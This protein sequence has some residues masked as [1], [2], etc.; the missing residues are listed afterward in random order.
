MAGEPG[1]LTNAQAA[2]LAGATEADIYEI[3]RQEMAG[4]LPVA[5]SG[6]PS[7]GAYTRGGEPF[8]PQVAPPRR[9]VRVEAISAEEMK[10]KKGK[11]S[12]RSTVT[13]PIQQ[14]MNDVTTTL[15]GIPKSGRTLTREALAEI[16]MGN[17]R[18]LQ[19]PTTGQ[20]LKDPA[21]GEPMTIGGMQILKAKGGVPLGQFQIG[22]P[23][24]YKPLTGAVD[25][26]ITINQAQADFMK[27]SPEVIAAMQDQ[28]SAGGWMGFDSKGEPDVAF[29]R[30]VADDFTMK[31]FASFLEYAMLRGGMRAPAA[32]R[33]ETP[34]GAVIQGKDTY[35]K[36]TG[37][38]LAEL[39]AE[40][41][42][43]VQEGARVF[44]TG[45]G[46]GGGGGGG[47]VI[48]PDPLAVKALA[49]QIG[50]LLMGRILT[51]AELNDIVTK[52]NAGAI[53][54]DATNQDFD[55]EAN[56]TE[57][58]KRGAGTSAETT[59]HDLVNMYSTFTGLIGPMQQTAER[60][61]SSPGVTVT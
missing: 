53:G 57:W 60:G 7:L 28:L 11:R 35:D 3:I 9:R 47:A 51:D 27:Q 18:P 21:T 2:F 39:M 45:G 54:A 10:K 26:Y 43:A 44:D 25:E 4:E 8:Q 29:A 31:A 46:G 12:A 17:A 48:M 24:Q 14:D 13:D 36:G 41:I 30:G 6:G 58:L 1:T 32:D 40:S 22:P 19:D 38:D 50:Q 59:A 52:V 16:L 37:Q 33:F 49:N 55:V 23:D 5:P 61:G 34:G 15:S 56:I 42:A 20:I